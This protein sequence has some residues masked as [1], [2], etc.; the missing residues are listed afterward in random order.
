MERRRYLSELAEHTARGRVFALIALVLA[1]SNLGLVAWA[2]SRDA[3]ERTIVTPPVIERAFWVEDAAASPAYL[4]QM[5]VFLAQLA[6]SYS[7]ANVEH[8]GEVFLRYADP[9]AYGVLRTRWLE[10]TERVKRNR[11]ASVFHPLEV[12]TRGRRVA[13]LGELRTLVGSKQT[14]QRRAAF[15]IDF[16]LRSGRLFVTEF[17]EVDHADPFGDRAGADRG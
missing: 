1:A 14:D 17:L 12:R 13:V 11:V 6:L 10:D 5:A 15:R 4:E 7:P 9:A 3:V 8:Q 2:M 16:A